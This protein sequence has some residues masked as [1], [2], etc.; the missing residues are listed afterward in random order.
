[1]PR[2]QLTKEQQL[3]LLS[4]Q[5]RAMEGGAATSQS[6]KAASGAGLHSAPALQDLRQ[7]I[8]ICFAKGGAAV[9]IL[10]VP[11]EIPSSSSGGTAVN[12]DEAAPTDF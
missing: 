5:R 2:A 8:C 1:M 6:S 9:Q 7:R 3:Q 12:H 10:L 11:L 4:D